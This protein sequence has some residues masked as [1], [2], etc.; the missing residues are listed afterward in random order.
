MKKILSIALVALLAASTVFAGFSGSATLGLGYDFETGKYGFS[1]SN[2]FDLN[3][4]LATADAEKVAEGDVYASIKASIAAKLVDG[5]DKTT[6]FDT[7]V[8]DG[9]SSKLA[10][11][12]KLDEAKVAGADWYVS[13]KGV[14]SVNDF[15]K[16]A[17]DKKT[18]KNDTDDFGFTLDDY[19]EALTY[20][21]AY[22]KLPGFEAGYKGYVAAAGFEGYTDK[23]QVAQT[24]PVTENTF[25]YTLNVKTP[26]YNFDVVTLQVGAEA[27]KAN[28]LNTKTYS[29]VGASAKVGFDA[30]AVS[31]FVAADTGFENLGK[32]DWKFED[33]FNVDVAAKLAISPV[34]VDAYYARIAN[35]DAKTENLLSAQVAVDLNAFDVPV[36]FTFTGKD[37]VNKQDLSVK[38]AFDITEELSADAS[39]G[40]VIDTKKLSTSANIAYTADAFTAKA[41]LG[42][43][44]TVDTEKSNYLTA[45]A[46][47]ESAAVIPGAVLKAEYK[48]GDKDMNLLSGQDNGRAKNYGKIV[49]SCKIAF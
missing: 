21:V 37:L 9:I 29:N 25:G 28:T 22:T 23:G 33:N 35:D 13:I 40:Y 12:A 10:V 44:L 36:A 11:V 19:K 4:D 49:T 15:A 42:Y 41:G 26:E 47:I 5:D 3:L 32:D 1:N 31:G 48:A 38:A 46:S 43:G 14:T 7:F 18:V 45:S 27:S 30:D 2:K 17:I 24:T 20:K 8:I 16:S 39:V 6:K 34:T